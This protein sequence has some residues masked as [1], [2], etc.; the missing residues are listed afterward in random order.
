MSYRQGKSSIL[1]NI[2]QADSYRCVGR[3]RLVTQ[4]IRKDHLDLPHYQDSIE[5]LEI[6]N[7]SDTI[8][9]LQNTMLF[10]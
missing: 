1:N 3:F 5:I 8:R 10:L 4:S 6:L 7:N 9:T 2:G